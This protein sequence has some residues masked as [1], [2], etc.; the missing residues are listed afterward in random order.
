MKN[1]VSKLS[2]KSN[3]IMMIVLY[4]LM[5]LFIALIIL[6]VLLQ[7][8]M[9]SNIRES[10]QMMFQQKAD[11][12]DNV[13]EIANFSS[14]AFIT[15][16]NNLSLLRTMYE[17]ENA[18]MRN[19][20]Q[21]QLIGVL[22]KDQVSVL[23]GFSGEVLLLTNNGKV[24]SSN[25]SYEAPDDY[26][27]S[28][29]YQAALEHGQFPYW[30]MGINRFVNRVLGGNQECFTFARIVQKYK[31]QNLGL[32]LVRIPQNVF[33]DDVKEQAFR[34]GSMD[35]MSDKGRILSG[36]DSQEEAEMAGKMLK[37]LNLSALKTDEFLGTRCG[38]GSYCMSTRLSS[39]DAILLYMGDYGLIFERPMKISRIMLYFMAAI[40]IAIMASVIK[41]SNFITEP[42]NNLVKNMQYIE[43]SGSQLKEGKHGF[44]EIQ[45]LEN[46]FR[47]A[48]ERIQRLIEDVREE[49][50]QKE[51]A[52]YEALQAQINPHFLFNTLNAIQWKAALN[53]D[54]EVSDMLS[55]LSVLLYETYD[56]SSELGT[57]G[58]SM[59]V[60]DAYVKIMKVRFGDR[61]SFFYTVQDGLEECLI[62]RFC[63]QPLVENSFLH[64]MTHVEDGLIVLR[65]EQ[66]ED[67]IELTL[68][69]NGR[70][71]DQKAPD[72]LL[73]ADQ[74]P[75][76]YKITGIGLSNIHKRVQALFGEEYGLEIDP[77]VEIGFRI[78]LKIPKIMK[79]ETKNGCT[80][81]SDIDR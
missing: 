31:G 62:P 58:Q 4:V 57:I 55:D 33:W 46:S 64:G 17:G 80:N 41:V 48:R 32:L 54:K 22:Q 13:I 45:E 12:I 59:V 23:A 47:R 61:V 37:D 60:L 49:T 18:Y 40:T 8:N 26:R 11:K 68:T 43:Q 19:K 63:L 25:A 67:H 3:M 65:V 50:E 14:S 73:T 75:K 34:K 1:E 72:T 77:S 29:W 53:D 71:A 30:D 56:H 51:K 24:L 70:G 74:V 79:G 42:I 27:D 2:I 44:R 69:D 16:D 78:T 6:S 39:N 76:K 52:Y 81:D 10:Y 20:A 7:K 5:P 28:E 9:S 66:V 36:V 35:M 15:D 21:T 38:S